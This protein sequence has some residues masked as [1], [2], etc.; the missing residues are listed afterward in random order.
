[1]INHNFI[2]FSAVQVYDL[3]YIH[4]NVFNLHVNEGWIWYDM[5][6]WAP[7]LALGKRLKV[8]SEMPYCACLSMLYHLKNAVTW[9]CNVKHTSHL[10]Y[11]GMRRRFHF[12]PSWYQVPGYWPSYSHHFRTVLS[13]HQVEMLHVEEQLRQSTVIGESIIEIYQYSE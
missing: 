9:P 3:S 2:S 8:Y 12:S 4:L 10:S 7:R 5:K 6:G 11:T 1:M 13:S